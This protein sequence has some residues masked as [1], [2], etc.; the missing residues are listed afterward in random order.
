MNLSIG[1]NPISWTNDDMQYVGG[2][3][4]LETCLSDASTAGYDGVELGH[5][6]P[7]DAQQLRPVLE[8]HGLA[9]VSGWYSGQLAVRDSADEI[10]AMTAHANLLQAMNCNVL[11]FAEVTGCIHGSK[12]TRLS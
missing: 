12:D 3:I 6:F 2:H 7:R 8:R 4:S 10:E 1:I 11:I 5:K 9:L